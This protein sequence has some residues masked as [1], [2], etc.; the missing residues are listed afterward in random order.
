MTD[1]NDRRHAITWERR[2]GNILGRL[3]PP[4]G[5]IEPPVSA[6]MNWVNCCAV[7]RLVTVRVNNTPSGDRLEGGA[8]GT[9]G[10]RRRG[11]PARSDRPSNAPRQQI[12][13]R[14]D[15]HAAELLFSCRYIAN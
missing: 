15:D 3:Q 11:H 12:A 1:D 13:D 14:Y 9:L 10:H 5:A 8:T 7:E 4:V 2:K 6:M